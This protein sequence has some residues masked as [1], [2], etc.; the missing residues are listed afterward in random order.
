[1]ESITRQG[2][3]TI[4]Q[5]KDADF[6]KNTWDLL[7]KRQEAQAQYPIKCTKR[8]PSKERRNLTLTLGSERQKVPM[9]SK[10]SHAKIWSL[11]KKESYLLTLY[12]TQR[13][14]MSASMK[15]TVYIL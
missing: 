12:Q 3:R 13:V 10:G 11:N 4:Y 2:H 9:G 1:M 15:Q 7:N 14:G 6:S 8:F 5:T